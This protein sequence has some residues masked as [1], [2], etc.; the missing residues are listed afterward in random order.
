MDYGTLGTMYVSMYVFSQQ[1]LTSF[2]LA[3]AAVTFDIPTPHLPLSVC[4]CVLGCV[5]VAGDPVLAVICRHSDWQSASFTTV[6]LAS[7]ILYYH[8]LHLQSVHHIHIHLISLSTA[9][10]HHQS[11]S[12]MATL[13]PESR[14]ANDM[15]LKQESVRPRWPYDM[16]P[17]VRAEKYIRDASGA[18]KT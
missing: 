18:E 16:R 11:I 4:V 1:N 17:S 5:G 2:Q 14:I 9:H 8:S 10:H 6:Q 13:R 7:L 12:L 3:R 15:Q